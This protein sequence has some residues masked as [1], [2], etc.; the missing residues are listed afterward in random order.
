VTWPAWLDTAFSGSRRRATMTP[1]AADTD[2][3]DTTV[4]SWLGSRDGDW[5]GRTAGRVIQDDS[6]P[7]PQP[8]PAEQPARPS[9]HRSAQYSAAP[10]SDAPPCHEDRSAGARASYACRRSGSG[11]T[12]ARSLGRG[13]ARLVRCGARG[14]GRDA[15]QHLARHAGA[16][17]C[18]E[19]PGRRWFPLNRRGPKSRGAATG[20]YGL[21]ARA[22]SLAQVSLRPRVRL[23]TSRPGVESGSGQK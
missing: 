15:G 20:R 3:R 21:A 12:P 13:R 19:G 1:G 14:H 11:V 23:K 2:S 16:P 6:L 18:S 10:R 7:R 17:A 4:A 8:A 5:N 22:W 9:A